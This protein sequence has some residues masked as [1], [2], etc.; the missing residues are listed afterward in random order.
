MSTHI[1]WN[2]IVKNEACLLPRLWESI[3]PIISHA[4]VLDTGSSDDTLSVLRDLAKTYDVNLYLESYDY[5]SNFAFSTARNRALRCADAYIEK[6][7]LPRTRTYILLL[8][9]DMTLQGGQRLVSFLASSDPTSTEQ[10]KTVTTG[11]GLGTKTDTSAPRPAWC[12]VQRCGTLEYKNV[13]VI[14]AQHLSNIRYD[15]KIRTHE[16]IR[17]PL[18][19][20]IPKSVCVIEDKCDG[21]NRPQK[22]TRDRRILE[23]DINP[24][25]LFYLAQTYASRDITRDQAT[26]A[27]KLRYYIGGG[28]IQ[29]RYMSALRVAQQAARNKRTGDAIEWY[30]RAL[31]L[32]PTR[33]EAYTGL[34]QLHLNQRQYQAAQIWLD[35]ARSCIPA[36]PCCDWLFYKTDAW[37]DLTR[38]RIVCAYYTNRFLEGYTMCVKLGV[39][40]GSHEPDLQFYAKPLQPVFQMCL[41]KNGQTNPS[42]VKTSYQ[43]VYVNVREVNYKLSPQGKYVSSHPQ[44]R[45]IS[46]NTIYKL[47]KHATTNAWTKGPCIS[48][49]VGDNPPSGRL[50]QGYEDLRLFEGPEGRLDAVCTAQ[51]TSETAAN[52]CLWLKGVLHP[53]TMQAV[54]FPRLQACEKNWVPLETKTPNALGIAYDGLQTLKLQTHVPPLR[55]QVQHWDKKNP[56]TK[57][58]EVLAPRMWRGGTQWVRW[59]GPQGVLGYLHVVHEIGRSFDKIRCY[60]HR[61]VFRALNDFRPLGVSRLF[62]FRRTD[63]VE[64]AAGLAQVEANKLAVTFG[65]RDTEAW[66]YVFDNEYVR[67]QLVAV[68]YDSK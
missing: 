44:N 27:Y 34:V 15:T 43:D 68:E 18:S 52:E 28:S 23:E 50:I 10:A 5:G 3:G 41:G 53:P 61:F 11:S 49:I 59:V 13:R 65:Y 45:I 35:T 60:Y 29:E 6:Y 39:D 51:H 33:P 16:F 17:V 7:A 38:Q 36:A 31:G 22:Y 32:D 25:A 40:I 8:D 48:S 56:R 12:V 14:P 58:G 42:V 26:W 62:Y 57:E 55:T 67:A 63:Q 4:V 46:N 21:N 1:I 37:A 66:M 54:R 2:G 47:T 24:R 9:A 64:F 20:N 19:K 30:N